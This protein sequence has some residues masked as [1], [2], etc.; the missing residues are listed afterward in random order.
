MR[1]SFT[2]N[3][4]RFVD[5]NKPHRKSGSLNSPRILWREGNDRVSLPTQ[6]DA[7]LRKHADYQRVYQGSRKHFSRSMTYFFAERSSTPPRRS[8]RWLDCRAGSRQGCGAQPHQAPHA[9]VGALE[10]VLA[11]AGRR[12]GAASPANGSDGG[13]CRLAKR[14]IQD[15]CR[16]REGC[17]K[18]G[19][20]RDEHS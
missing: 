13:I 18:A 11:D 10:P 20:K 1:L 7:R 2:E 3:R 15:L 12:R 8:A 9:R 6:N 14:S 16:R 4:M 19:E 5:S 17:E